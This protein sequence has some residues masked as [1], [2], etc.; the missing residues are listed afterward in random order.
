MGWNCPNVGYKVITAMYE[1]GTPEKFVKLT[2][3]TLK[4]TNG[5]V[6]T[7]VRVS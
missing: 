5:K 3:M 1:I 6:K 4:N 2:L 7:A